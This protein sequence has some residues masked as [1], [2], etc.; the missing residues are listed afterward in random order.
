[1]EATEIMY[2]YLYEICRKKMYLSNIKY[3]RWTLIKDFFRRQKYSLKIWLK[4]KIGSISS[5]LFY[6]YIISK[7]EKELHKHREKKKELRYLRRCNCGEILIKKEGHYNCKVC[8]YTTKYKITLKERIGTI[9]NKIFDLKI[10][11][12][13]TKKR[14]RAWYLFWNL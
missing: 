4:V 9:R 14:I 2:W 11:I 10:S 1:M 5:K 3:S 12:R 6:S 7:F 8:G 13:K